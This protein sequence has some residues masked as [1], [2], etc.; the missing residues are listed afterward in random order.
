S[1]A[2]AAFERHGMRSW[3]AGDIPRVVTLPGTGGAVRGYPALV[4]EGETAGG[5]VMDTPEAQAAAMARGTRRLLMLALATPRPRLDNRVALAL[6]SA[7]HGSLD[8][9]V[10]D[11]LPA[12]IDWLPARSRRPPWG[13]AGGGALAARR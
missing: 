9:V 4:D 11:A 13:G 12:T 7:P 3:E 2:S 8:A 1:S 6:A 5:G 10:A